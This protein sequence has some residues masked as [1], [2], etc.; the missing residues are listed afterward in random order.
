MTPLRR[1]HFA[2]DRVDG[3]VDEPRS[4]TPRSATDD[5]VEQVVITGLE[6]APPGATHWSTR[7][8][9]GAT[10]LSHDRQS[11]LAGLRVTSPPER[12]LDAVARPD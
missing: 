1:T 7:S 4:G 2:R 11:H 8:L 6:T 3:L 5:Q 12:D 10:G 9:A